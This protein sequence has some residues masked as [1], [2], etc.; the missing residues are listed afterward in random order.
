MRCRFAH[1]LVPL[2][3]DDEG[4]SAQESCDVVLGKNLFGLEL[5]S[6]CTQIAA[7]ALALAAW[8]YP[9][10]DGQPLGYRTL[11]PLNIACSGQSVAGKKEEWLALANGDSRLREGMDNLYD[12]FRQAPHLGSLIDPSREVG[13]LLAAGFV[14]LEPLLAK[15]LSREKTT[16]NVDAIAVGV[17]AQG[18]ARAAKMLSTS[19]TLIATNVPYLARSKHFDV[20]YYFCKEKHDAGKSDLATVFLDRFLRFVRRNGTVA[21]VSPQNRLFLSACARSRFQAA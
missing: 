13:D 12:L 7:F 8:K 2:R 4:L 1:M 19:Y 20:I 9:G 5:E 17:A 3:M 18:I 21:V 16:E 15:A 6:R 10:E 11:P 14:E